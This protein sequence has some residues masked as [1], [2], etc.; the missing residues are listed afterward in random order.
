MKTITIPATATREQRDVLI[1]RTLLHLARIQ[2][3]VA[4]M[5]AADEQ[6]KKHQAKPAC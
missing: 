5:R 4:R 1:A 2:R 3:K 6:G